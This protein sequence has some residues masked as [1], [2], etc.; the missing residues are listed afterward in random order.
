MW[1]PTP[2]LAAAL[3]GNHTMTAR[4]TV[5]NLATGAVTDV[6]I[7]AGTVSA[8][9]TQRVTRTAE[10]TVDAGVTDAGLLNPLTDLVAIYSGVDQVGE[11]PLFT[12]RPL[13]TVD[14]TA[15]KVTVHCS[16][17]GAELVAA[18]FDRPWNT[19][20]GRPMA[21][22]IG[23]IVADVDPT[24][25]VDTSRAPTTAVPTLIW[26]D[27][28]GKA[29]DDLAAALNCVLQG[30]RTG[31][32]VLYPNP[33]TLDPALVTPVG[34]VADGA[35]GVLVDVSHTR[36]REQIVNS[37]TVV[38]ERTD[39]SV[40]I[41][42]TVRDTDP[43][44]ATRWG[45]P[46]GKAARIVKNRQLSNVD[47]ATRFA[48]RILRQSLALSRSWQISLPHY[49]LYDPGDVLAVTYRGELTVQVV[50]TVRHNLL[51]DA[52]T[53]LTTRQLHYLADL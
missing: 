25:G 13:S 35:G 4:V 17:R 45:G 3:A 5:T 47:D 30:D 12:G 18:A 29:L 42:V 36:S 22:E 33:Y 2:A 50:E 48:T 34:S 32:F 53:Q 26:E 24:W 19:Y 27:D 40:P 9:Q 39:G 11:V 16:D 37:V 51:A 14:T 10:L 20:A 41:R 49:P 7:N 8:S 31:G 6:P 23:L 52:A 43:A 44:S 21:T 28:R 46:F 1:T 38:A 15:G